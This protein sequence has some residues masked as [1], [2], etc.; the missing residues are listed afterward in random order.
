MAQNNYTPQSYRLIE[1]VSA[2]ADNFG[3]FLLA[4]DFKTRQLVLEC[5]NLLDGDIVVYESNQY[6]QPDITQPNSSTNEYFPVGYTNKA[7]QVYYAVGFPFAIAGA[8]AA[9]NVETT[10]SRWITAGIINRT[11]GTIQKLTLTF[12]DNQ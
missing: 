8:G 11:T 2:G 4:A 9:F 6:Y 1:N 3:A 5:D 10:G 7:D 12:L